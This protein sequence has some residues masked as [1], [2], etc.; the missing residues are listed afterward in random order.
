MSLVCTCGRDAFNVLPDA[1]NCRYRCIA[2]GLVLTLVHTWTILQEQPAQATAAQAPTTAAQT[3]NSGKRSNDNGNI[4]DEHAD[5]FK[6]PRNMDE[7]PD[8]DEL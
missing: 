7:D 6:K 2:C 8:A 3:P 5:Q 4:D 1:G